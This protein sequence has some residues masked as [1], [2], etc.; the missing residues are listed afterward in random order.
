MTQYH[1]LIKS[2][3][4]F[5]F[6]YCETIYICFFKMYY[7]CT[8]FIKNMSFFQ[9]LYRPHQ[10]VKLLISPGKYKIDIKDSIFQALLNKLLETVKINRKE[11]SSLRKEIKNFL[12]IKAHG[13]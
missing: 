11:K 3:M 8:F 12:Q 2:R 4:D 13:E 10:Y 1:S 5:V 6:W 7:C 9:T